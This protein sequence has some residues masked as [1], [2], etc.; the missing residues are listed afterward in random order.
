MTESYDEIEA[1]ITLACEE[2]SEYA[3]PNVAAAAREFEVPETRLRARWNGRQTKVDR[4]AANRK[5]LEEEELAVCLYLRRLDKIGT[6]ARLP[7]ITDCANSI[8]RR[9]HHLTDPETPPPTVSS[10]WT[11]RFLLRYPEFHVRKQKTLDYKRMNAHNP[12][13]ILDWFRRFK[14]VYEEKGIQPQDLYNYDETGFRI[15][16]GRDQWIVTLDPNRQSYLASSTN[17][18]LVTSCEVIS[19][20]GYVL[21]PMLILAGTMHLEDWATKTDLEDNV[22]LSVSDTGYS[23]DLLGFEWLQHFERFSAQRQVGAYRML[24]LDGHG[25]HCTRDFITFCD[26]KNIIP[27]C[28]PAHTTHLIQPLDVVVFQPLKHFHA[29]AID[30]ATRTG[31]SDFNKIEFLSA[32]TSIRSQAFKKSTI[33]SAFQ[34]TGLVPYD[35]AKV[36]TRLQ[37]SHTAL[38]HPAMTTP[39]PAVPPPLQ[40]PTPYTVRSLKRQAQYLNDADPVS[41]TF[42]TNLDRFIKGSLTQAQSG[43]HA[44]QEL[45]NT[46]AAEQARATRQNRTRRSV[47]KGGVIYA[48]QARAIVR[49]KEEDSAQKKVARAEWELEQAKKE[50]IRDRKKR[51]KPY[52]KS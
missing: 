19:A 26:E 36:L 5:L 3:K 48:H 11:T 4:P 21:P 2:L 18:E 1:R 47:Q 15:G 50:A 24:L 49:K 9:N 27:F 13:D 33:I 46:Q 22:L 30:Y 10:A 34:K 37:E 17:R 45:A 14:S 23:N 28:L 43:A 25:S 7:M 16:I 32:L 39:P 44:Y 31:C 8:L 40:V 41:P 38:Q 42:K 52:F 20:D 29:E 51:W 12:E 6:S 35:P